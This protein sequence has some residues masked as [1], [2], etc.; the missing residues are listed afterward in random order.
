MRNSEGFAHNGVISNL[1]IMIQ[2]SALYALIGKPAKAVKFS[3]D[4]VSPTPLNADLEIYVKV[5][6][7]DN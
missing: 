6:K 7:I 5:T 2:W 3:T 1:H 4:F